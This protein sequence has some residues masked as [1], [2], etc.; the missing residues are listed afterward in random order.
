MFMDGTKCGNFSFEMA[1]LF[2]SGHRMFFQMAMHIILLNT[3]PIKIHF[4][5]GTPHA[6]RTL[7]D[8]N[9]E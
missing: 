8:T 6:F 4:T 7:R 5:E 2:N 9:P 3:F 1:F